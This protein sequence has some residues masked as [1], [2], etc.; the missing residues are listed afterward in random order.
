MYVAGLGVEQNRYP[1]LCART[2]IPAFG[3]GQQE[4]PATTVRKKAGRFY[5]LCICFTFTF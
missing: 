5:F 2:E 1:K 3:L 4:I